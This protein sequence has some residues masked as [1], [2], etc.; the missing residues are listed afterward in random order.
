[1]YVLLSVIDQCVSHLNINVTFEDGAL[2]AVQ[3]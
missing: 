1:M 3:I 2:W